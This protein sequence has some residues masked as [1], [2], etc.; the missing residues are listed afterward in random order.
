MKRPGLF[1]TVILTCT[2][3]LILVGCEMNNEA[4]VTIQAVIADFRSTASRVD[5]D[6]DVSITPTDY[7]IALTYFAL[8]QDDGT[9]VP[10]IESETPVVYDFSD[11]VG[12][13]GLLLGKKTV[14][15]ATYSGYEMRF[16]YLEM[17][18][19]SAFAVP[20]ESVDADHTLVT[21]S[22]DDLG[23]IRHF[24]N[25]YR[26]YFN[27]DGEY[28]K[29]DLVVKTGEDEAGSGIWSWM[30]R[31][32]EH[33]ADAFFIT[34]ATHP[35]QEIGLIDLFSNEAFWGSADDYDN[36]TTLITVSTEDTSGGVDARIT[37]FS[38][39]LDKTLL[40]TIDTS[41]TFSFKETLASEYDNDNLDLGPYLDA[42]P[43]GTD[44]GE[45][46]RYGDHGYHPMM[47]AFNLS[48]IE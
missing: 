8:I 33:A 44:S 2:F 37:P 40:L 7:K 27:T 12:A 11:S 43:I 48:G 41:N 30:R 28:Y 10:I 17:D 5:E 42:I 24:I 13:T 31:A 36:P 29:R 4:E 38:L 34:S 25:T 20:S 26:M 19:L 47:P 32:I 6:D 23:E 16:T 15:K 18:L 21:E 46:H 39:S 3:F 35:S 14:P 1:L 45:D 22:E 9:V